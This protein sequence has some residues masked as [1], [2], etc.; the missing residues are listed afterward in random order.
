MT[1]TLIGNEYIINDHWYHEDLAS[2]LLM[3]YCGKVESSLD[4]AYVYIHIYFKAQFNVSTFSFLAVFST[5]NTF[6][7]RFRQN[8]GWHWRKKLHWKKGDLGSCEGKGAWDSERGGQW[9]C[10]GETW[11][12]PKGRLRSLPHQSPLI[13]S[14]VSLH[15]IQN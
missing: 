10:V 13:A 8:K 11:G 15:K 2:F 9:I 14:S 5:Y 3:L 12:W 6:F 1:L 7:Y 4:Y